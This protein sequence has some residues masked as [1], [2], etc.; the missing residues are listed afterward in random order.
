M[1]PLTD[2]DRWIF[3]T[4]VPLF[5]FNILGEGLF[6]RGYIFP[7]QKLAFKQYTWF[8]HGCCWWTFHIPFGSA[9]LMTLIP[10]IF[11]TSFVVQKTKNTWSDIIIHSLINRSGFLLVAFRIA[12]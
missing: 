4:W 1:P 7:R 6:W 3:A 11:T 12:G 8:V 9:L 2:R 5:L 10:I